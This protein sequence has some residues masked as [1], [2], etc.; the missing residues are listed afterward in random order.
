MAFNM[1]AGGLSACLWLIHSLVPEKL[2]PPT[3]W[4]ATQ[5]SALECLPQG[6]S[7]GPGS[8]KLK[9]AA[10]SISPGFSR[11]LWGLVYHFHDS[12]PQPTSH[13][14]EG[15]GEEVLASGTSSGSLLTSLIL[16]NSQMALYLSKMFPGE[17]PTGGP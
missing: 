10:F 15:T 7:S 9:I 11:Q 1:A 16:S 3:R 14:H 6:I 12:H 13:Q 2:S 17:R 8:K 4:P 5:Q